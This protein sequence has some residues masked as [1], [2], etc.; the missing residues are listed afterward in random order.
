MN[1]L[2]RHHGHQFTLLAAVTILLLLA[3]AS[4]FVSIPSVGALPGPGSSPPLCKHKCRRCRPCKAVRVVI[5]PGFASKAD[6]YPEA[7][8]CKCKDKIFMP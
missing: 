7:W 5:N 2:P 6:Y 4:A 8:R 3:S 1:F